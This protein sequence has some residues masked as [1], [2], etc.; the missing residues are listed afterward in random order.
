MRKI[1]EV[2]CASLKRS[3][4]APV[5]GILLLG[6]PGLEARGGA[7]AS[8]AAESE[9]DAQSRVWAQSSAATVHVD[10]DL[11]APRNHDRDYTGGLSLNVPRLEVPKWWEP[12]GWIAGTRLDPR[13]S[14]T[15]RAIQWSAIAFT[16]GVLDRAE[17]L[18]GERPYASLWALTGARMAVRDG[19]RRATY[20]AVTVGILGMPITGSVH[21]A[22]HRA[23]GMI[24]P[25]GYGHQI[26]AGGE[27]AARLK[28]ADRV[29][30]RGGDLGRGLDVWRTYALSVGYLTEGS[31]SL[32]MRVGDRG[33][34]WWASGHDLDDYAPA[35]SFGL[36]PDGPNSTVELGARVKVRGYNA[37]L[38]GQFRHSDLRYSAS[39]VKPLV[40]EAWIGVSTRLRTGWKIQYALRGET[41]ELKGGN[42]NRSHLWGSVTLET[43]FD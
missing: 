33:L 11:F 21:R 32:A 41:S 7:L 23:G 15:V 9:S 2:V 38:Q 5:F 26:S 14:R 17:P 4:W 34:P 8:L 39:E 40:A 35:P 19:N 43:T 29:L 10:N 22:L 18:A 20:S 30:L 36:L 1:H 3:L 42:A 25:A 28:W 6:S 27:L 12:D 13:G 24:E 37:F 31:F 16:P